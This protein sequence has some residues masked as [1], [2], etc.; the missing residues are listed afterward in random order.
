MGAL[1]LTER[2]LILAASVPVLYLAMVLLGRLLK[3]NKG[4]RLGWLYHL[5]ALSLAVFTPGY[6]LFQWPFIKELGALT[7]ISGAIFIIALIDRFVW[8]LYFQQKH[9]VK[10]P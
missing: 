1:P 4:V 6:F 2:E 8:Q 3:R 9:R 7:T 5:F 10:V